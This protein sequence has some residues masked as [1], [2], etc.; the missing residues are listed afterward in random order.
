MKQEIDLEHAS[1]LVKTSL[2]MRATAKELGVTYLMLFSKL[3][4]YQPYVA[5][6]V[7]RYPR[8]YIYRDSSVER[9]R[10]KRDYTEC[11]YVPEK[12]DYR[13]I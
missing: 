10:V 12:W 1:N 7:S 4:M 13:I 3:Y 6:R 5:W 8:R 9:V 2:D 11:V